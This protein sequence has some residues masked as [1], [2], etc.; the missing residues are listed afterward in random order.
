MIFC[1]GDLNR[2]CTIIFLLIVADCLLLLCLLSDGNSTGAQL[3]MASFTRQV[4]GLL[5]AGVTGLQGVHVSHHLE[6]L[7]TSLR[8]SAHVIH[9]PVGIIHT[10]VCSWYLHTCSLHAAPLFILFNRLSRAYSHESKKAPRET[11]PKMKNI[12]NSLY[13]SHLLTYHGTTQV[14]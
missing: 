5:L 9:I 1:V 6:H 3:I 11:S 12:F 7:L 8:I 4:V 2:G 10:H 13:V 14:T